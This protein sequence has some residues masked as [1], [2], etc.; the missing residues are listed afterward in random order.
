MRFFRNLQSR[1]R[2]S[3]PIKGPVS[4]EEVSLAEK[5]WIQQIQLALPKMNKDYK[6][7][8]E[9]LPLFEDSDKMIRCRGR[10]EVSNP[11]TQGPSHHTIGR[12]AVP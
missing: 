9:S 4:T 10:I 12:H 7:V 1:C 6:T 11:P 3:N 2:E 8:K 5:M